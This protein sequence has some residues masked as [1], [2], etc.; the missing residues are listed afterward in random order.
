[1]LRIYQ[2]KTNSEHF[3]VFVE[4]SPHADIVVHRI[5]LSGNTTVWNKVYEPRWFDRLVRSSEKRFFGRWSLLM[6]EDNA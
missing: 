4:M 3:L 1:M 5:S 6:S 2:Y